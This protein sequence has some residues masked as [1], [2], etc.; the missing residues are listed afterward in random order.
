MEKYEMAVQRVLAGEAL[1]QVA[2]E[3]GINRSTASVLMAGVRIALKLKVGN[4]LS[5]ADNTGLESTELKKLKLLEAE[6]ERLKEMLGL[7]LKLNTLMQKE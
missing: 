2:R 1:S 6:N 7:A 4:V 5:S 3:L